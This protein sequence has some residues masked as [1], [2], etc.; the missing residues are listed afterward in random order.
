MTAANEPVEDK[1]PPQGLT[2]ATPLGPI[3]A[4]PNPDQPQRGNLK[5][6]TPRTAWAVL[7]TSFDVDPR[8]MLTAYMTHVSPSQSRWTSPEPPVS[9]RN[10][11]GT[12]ED[13]S[14]RMPLQ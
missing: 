4:A 9:L 7:T 14:W 11:S 5:K 12:T 8:Q 10:V 2:V 13:R 1:R 6:Q 3:C